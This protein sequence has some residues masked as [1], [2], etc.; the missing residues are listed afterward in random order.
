MNAPLQLASVTT[1]P[2]ACPRPLVGLCAHDLVLSSSVTRA[3]LV[4]PVDAR[5]I[6]I[7][8]DMVRAALDSIECEAV[9]P[10]R[11]GRMPVGHAARTAV[12]IPFPTRR[13]R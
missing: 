11:D 13:T 1:L 10:Y 7:T 8:D 2:P 4:D 3:A 5:E 9:T 6:E 12:V